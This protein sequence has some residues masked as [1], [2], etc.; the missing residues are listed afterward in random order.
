MKPFSLQHAA[1]V[2]GVAVSTIFTSNSRGQS[3][4][5]LLDK[6]VEKGVLTQ[7]DASELRD[8]MDQGFRKAYQ[9]KSGMP[10]WVTALKLNGDFRGRVETI[11]AENDAF[12]DR[13]RFRYRLRFGAVAV[14]KDNFEVGLRLTSAE[15]IQGTT[16]NAGLSGGDPI[17]GN[18][19]L[20]ENASKKWIYIDLAYA[21]WYALNTK[22]YSGSL[23]IG[24]MENPFTWA[25]T[26]FSS[27][28]FDAD[29]T[30]EGGAIN[31]TWRPNS[32]HSLQFNGGAYVLDEFGTSVDPYMLA[33]QTRWNAT[34]NKRWNSTLGAAILS[35]QNAS[36]LTNG[37]VPNVQVGNYRVGGTGV[38][39]YGFNPIFLDAALG[40]TFD[41]GPLYK[42]PFPIRVWG[43]YLNNPAAPSSADN[44]GWD[45]GISFGKAGKKGLWELTYLNRFYGAN[46]WYEEV[47]DSDLGA[48]YSTPWPNSGM[49][50]ANASSNYR[51]GTNV[52]GHIFRVSYSPYDALTLQV[53]A[54]LTALIQEPPGGDNSEVAR[55]QFDA[56]WKF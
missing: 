28:L 39:Q 45:A 15:P 19:T 53:T 54:A 10:D 21:K 13:T 11:Q 29:Y 26:A 47:V 52:R 24:K 43:E 36:Q 12:E 14:I 35:I 48:Y 7:K 1:A 8:E 20:G 49:S 23:T 5:A 41:Q 4:D 16:G 31:F 55:I 30:P 27:M 38:L 18:T 17:S 50:A 32:I 2:A 34:W 40:Y 51:A 37:A 3:A 9:V 56:I 46:A 42:Q 25:P 44:Y 22:Q 6:L 33:A